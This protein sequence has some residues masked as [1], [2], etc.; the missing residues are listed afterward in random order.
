MTETDIPLR[1]ACGKLHGTALRLAPSAGTRIVCYCTDCQAFARF[2][3]VPGITDEWG[4]TG[5]FQMAPARVRL[6]SDTDT[7]ACVRLSDKGMHRFYCSECKTPLGNTMGPRVPFVGLI[8]SFMKP[9]AESTLDA[10]L[11]PVL[12]YV[13]A[14]SAL[15]SLPPER[16]SGLPRVIARS[17]RLLGKWWLTG[18]GVPSP[19]F[20]ERTHT[21]RVTPRILTAAERSAL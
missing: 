15:G 7:L 3:G 13:Q 11:G 2:L 17:V 19:F 12:G 14:Q 20:D 1:C 10:V 18:A 21:P 8:Q 4:G 6:E 9:N 16:K 5:I